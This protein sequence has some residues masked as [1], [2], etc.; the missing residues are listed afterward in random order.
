M[1][2]IKNFTPRPYQENISSIAKDKNTLVCLPTGT[3]KTKIGI[4]TAVA[5]L[6]RFE[7]S[8]VITLTPTKP[9]AQ[10]IWNEFKTNTDIKEE[11]ISLLTGSILPSKRKEIY[12]YSKIIIAT[13]QT[14]QKDI[15]N[16][17]VNL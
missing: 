3:G 1:M 15:E 5:R 7:N 8:K 9:L 11:E 12:K 16:L 4:L 2:E 17:R 10:Q 13:P 6:N 14:I